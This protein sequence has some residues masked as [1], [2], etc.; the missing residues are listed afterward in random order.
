MRNIVR[1][2]YYNKILFPIMRKFDG[3]ALDD[4]RR[5][6]AVA[7]EHENNHTSTV[8]DAYPNCHH[9]LYVIAAPGGVATHPFWATY[10]AMEGAARDLVRLNK[11][12]GEPEKDQQELT[13]FLIHGANA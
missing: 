1:E 4:Y 9:C 2:L 3:G 7:E 5:G 10:D 13:N 12:T 11:R 6:M 8:P